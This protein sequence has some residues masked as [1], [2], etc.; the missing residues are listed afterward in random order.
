M[1]QAI[2]PSWPTIRREFS[3]FARLVKLEHSVF[4]LPFA[5]I[6][7]FLA[8][9]G[10]PGWKTFLFLT[11]AMV[12]IRS[13]AMAINRLADEKFDRQNPRTQDRPLVTGQIA[14]S[15]AWM[16]T[17][18]AAIVFVLS[19]FGLNMVCVYLSPLALLWSGLYSYSKRVTW[20]CHFWL[21]TVL[22]LAPLGG[23]L[24][25]TASLSL[26][27][28][29]FF[30]GVTF[31][32]AGFDILYACQDVDFDTQVG[33]KSLPARFGIPGALLLSTFSHV[34][35]SVFFLVAGWAAGLGWIYGLVWLAVS[36]V[37]IWEHT[38]V[39]ADD[40]GRLNLAFFTLN[41]IIAVVLCA[42]VLAD[43]FGPL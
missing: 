39:Q 23:W 32:V 13:F 29:L 18:G 9:G 14:R 43:M 30:F 16:M 6:G 12:A 33:L 15:K 8:A 3:L 1:F 4:A 40:L 21:G 25:E 36:I 27:A 37:L 22:G 19:C 35:A 41:G 28:V 5:Y 10:W 17:V 7:V 26:S 11:L 24:A 2:P 38:L 34:N 31:W 20:L 42:G